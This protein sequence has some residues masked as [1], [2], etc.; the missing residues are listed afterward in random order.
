MFN[1]E[2]ETHETS[3]PPKTYSGYMTDGD[4]AEENTLLHQC[5][6]DLFDAYMKIL[7][8]IPENFLLT[9]KCFKTNKEA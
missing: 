7:L 1:R 9:N 3:I 6:V 8:E 2:T 4:A 5:G